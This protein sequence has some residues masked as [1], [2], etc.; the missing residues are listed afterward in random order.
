MERMTM[1]EFRDATNLRACVRHLESLC[2]EVELVSYG[3]A[4]NP[5]GFCYEILEGA[6]VGWDMIEEL[7]RLLNNLS[8]REEI[9][10]KYLYLS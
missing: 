2:G 6:D 1:A 7:D 4:P 9:E 10:L 3:L 5:N 8:N